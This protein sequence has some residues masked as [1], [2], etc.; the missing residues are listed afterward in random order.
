MLG[1]VCVCVCVRVCACVRACVC[2]CARARVCVCACMC[3]RTAQEEGGG[4]LQR[5]RCI[6]LQV[7]MGTSF[8]ERLFGIGRPLTVFETVAKS[9]RERTAHSLHCGEPPPIP[10]N[11][12]CALRAVRSRTERAVECALRLTC[13]ML[14]RRDA[15]SDVACFRTSP[16]VVFI[17]IAWWAQHRSVHV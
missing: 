3:A 15:R 5:G 14:S 11:R 12:R 6:T 8:Q 1:C 9:K 13:K 7:E 4:G 2:V 17:S 16:L 10:S